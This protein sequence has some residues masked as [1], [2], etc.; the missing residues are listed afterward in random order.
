MWNVFITNYVVFEA[1]FQLW[2]CHE[3]SLALVA[4]HCDLWPDETSGWGFP[5]CT[6]LAGYKLQIP[7]HPIQR[8]IIV[9]TCLQ[10]AH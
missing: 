6:Y 5:E 1:V 3:P 10:F 8:Q 2:C 7:K 4:M 9:H